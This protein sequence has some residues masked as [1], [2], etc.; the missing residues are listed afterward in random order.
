MQLAVS[1]EGAITGTSEDEEATRFEFLLVATSEGTGGRCFLLAKPGMKLAEAAKVRRL[2]PLEYEDADVAVARRDGITYYECSV[3][4]RLMRKAIRPTEGRE[5]SL[6][7]LV[8][9]PDGTGIRDWGQTAGLWPSQRNRLA[10][11]RWEGAKWGQNPP[12]DNK[13]QW[14]MCTSKY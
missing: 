7:V 14:G 12:F 8:H 13:L 1:P 11:S 10:W 5:F 4:F 6:S 9:D 3:P 2:E